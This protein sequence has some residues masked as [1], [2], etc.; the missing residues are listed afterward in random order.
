MI[1]LGHLSD[2]IKVKM[3]ILMTLYGHFNLPNT[4]KGGYCN[5]S[6]IQTGKKYK[7]S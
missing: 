6:F 1:I 7:V 3:G 2:S 4:L 5:R